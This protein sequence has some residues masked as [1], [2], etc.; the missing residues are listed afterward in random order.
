MH[1]VIGIYKPMLA[2]YVLLP[3]FRHWRCVLRRRSAFC[4]QNRSGPGAMEH[5]SAKV[6]IRAM[7]KAL[8]YS[9]PYAL[10]HTLLPY[11]FFN[12]LN[13]Y[14]VCAV[15]CNDLVPA[16]ACMFLA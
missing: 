4:W 14:V 5:I 11:T 2:V 7:G 16:R 10:C 8:T 3:C 1:G 12:V 15:L 6:R 13:R 9:L